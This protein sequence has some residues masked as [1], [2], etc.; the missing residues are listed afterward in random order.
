MGN[1]RKMNVGFIRDER[2]KSVVEIYGGEQKRHAKHHHLQ[3][4]K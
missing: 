2:R 1:D 3:P 4:K